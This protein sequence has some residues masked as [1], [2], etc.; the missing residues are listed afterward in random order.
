MQNKVEHLTLF[1]MDGDDDTD[2]KL[3]LAWFDQWAAEVNV[4][5]YSSGGWEH[6]WDIQATANAAASVPKDWLCDSEWSNPTLF[7]KSDSVV[8]RIKSFFGR[9][10][11]T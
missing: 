4:V 2:Y 5:D 8:G 9:S 3:A 10:K 7:T 11:K 1:V 6:L